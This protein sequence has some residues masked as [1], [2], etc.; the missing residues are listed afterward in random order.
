M[1]ETEREKKALEQ[2]GSDE[3]EDQHENEILDIIRSRKSPK[4]IH[5]ELEDYHE[6]DIAS[7]LPDLDAKERQ[8]LYRLMTAEELA[9]ILEYVDAD[10]TD[11]YLDE[12]DPKK[13]ASTLE[14]MEA[15][16]AVDVLK[17]SKS[18]K[19]QA[20]LELMNPEARTQF[21]ALASYDEELIG[22]RMT[23]NFV[24]LRAS[25]T[26]KEAM[27]SVITQAAEHDNISVLFVLDA[28]GIYYGAVDLKDLIIARA[29]TR[30]ENIITTNYPYVY[31]DERVDDCLERGL[32]KARRSCR[33]GRPEGTAEGQYQEAASVAYPSAGTRPRRFECCEYV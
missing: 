9:G 26:I 7:A 22:S 18:S 5:D 21:Q 29:D 4:V 14:E 24:T 10:E 28:N 13:A 32:R 25:L 6:N 23:T 19:K 16:T 11:Q 8:V 15:D 1:S 30:L 2:T 31:A 27:T 20:W 17:N 33:R 12:M 3:R